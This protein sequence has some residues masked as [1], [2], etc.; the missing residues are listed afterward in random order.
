MGSTS[1]KPES[2]AP[3]VWKGPSSQAGVSQNLV[4]S[5]ETSNE[6]DVSR[7]Q[8]LELRIQ[9]RVAAELKR[10]RAQEAEALR[11]AQQKLSAEPAPN[12]QGEELQ[13][14]LEGGPSR[15]EVSKAVDDL[16]SKLEERKKVRQLPDSLENARSEV[17]RCLRENDRRPLDCWREVEAFKEEVRR[18]EKGWV[19]KVIS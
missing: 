10:L 3:H 7:L 4:E 19:E 14:Q 18:L 9:E 6:T 8:A 1:S 17:V 16:R 15:Q 5:L 11:E 2:S 12:Q 13:K